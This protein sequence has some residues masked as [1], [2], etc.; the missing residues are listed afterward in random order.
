MRAYERFMRYVQVDTTPAPENASVQPST[1]RQFDLARMLVK[2]MQEM[3]I[4]DARV[5]EK[6]Y[7]YGTIPAS[8][9][10]EY[11]PGLGLIAHMDTS[12]D[13]PGAN[14][15]PVL[16]PG[17]DGGDVVLPNGRVIDVLTFPNLKKMQG[18]TLITASG[19]TLLGADDKAGIAEI[20]TACDQIIKEGRPHPKL[21][22]A[23]TP[24]EEIGAGANGF[25]V[26]GFG[27]AYA[28]TIDGGEV[29]EVEYETFNAASAKV[30]FNG[31]SV[32]PG[33]AKN[34]MVNAI[35]LGI[36]FAG[37]LP[38]EE[39]PE[40]TEGREGFY[41]LMHYTGD[42]EQAELVYI[43]R[44]HDRGI[45]EQRKEKMKAAAQKMAEKYGEEKI[46]L[47]ITD[48]YYNMGEIIEQ[49]FHL[50]EDAREA[51]RMAG[52]EP[53]TVAVRGGTDGSRL[54]FMGLPCPNLGTGA[55]YGHGPNECVSAENMD[56]AVQV[57]L[58]LIAI[59]AKK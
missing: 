42:I 28:Y 58:N 19:D 59:N 16:H 23:F 50:V 4:S 46:R 45:F 40:Q 29:C 9:G 44:D 8:V 53:T 24:D 15:R 43:I 37:L 26:E 11:L 41:H 25:D 33:S 10:C 36:E 38:S 48:S 27:A 1:Q 17:Y 6:C 18:Q 35:K 49:H 31:V 14:V 51:I 32:H 2:E 47:E 54:S 39:C 22:I 7:V 57:I 34:I 52:A 20:L 30:V 3:G 5:D 12:P 21:C 56:E 13:A 55:F